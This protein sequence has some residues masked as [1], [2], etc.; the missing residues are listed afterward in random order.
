MLRHLRSSSYQCTCALYVPR[1][2]FGTYVVLFFLQKVDRC[3]RAGALAVLVMN[4]DQERPDA[5]LR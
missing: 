2:L 1:F 4:D 3:A 5:A